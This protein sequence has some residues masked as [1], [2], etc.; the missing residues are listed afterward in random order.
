MVVLVGV[1]GLLCVGFAVSVTE[2][3][4]LQ[5]E[6]VHGLERQLS[7]GRKEV[8]KVP[9]L[10]EN[11]GK[12][13]VAKK[14]VEDKF[15]ACAAEKDSLAAKAAELQK[16]IDTFGAIKAAVGVQISGLQATIQEQQNKINELENARN[17][18]V[19][20]LNAIE[21]ESKS[22]SEKFELQIADVK[23]SRDEIKNQLIYYTE[24]KK[25]ADQELAEKQRTITEL[26]KAKETLE[27][28]L[29]RIKQ[30]GPAAPPETS[31]TSGPHFPLMESG[32]PA[33]E[34]LDKTFALLRERITSPAI[35]LDEVSILLS[36]M[37]K[38][39]KSLK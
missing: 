33:A 21:V 1:F 25:I 32:N 37:E 31:S 19:E 24:A 27:A 12:V 14:E 23:R 38:A 13:E 28:E 18:L 4:R 20:Q 15:T 35:S 17:K 8:L 11:L 30:Q 9:E 29:A 3:Y 10:M 34:E 2:K 5:K 39:L 26:Q 6:R 22:A 36:R 7:A 16:E